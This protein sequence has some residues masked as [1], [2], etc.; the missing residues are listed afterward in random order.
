M[1]KLATA[2][3]I[4]NAVKTLTTMADTGA[5]LVEEYWHVVGEYGAF[6]DEELATIGM[7]A[8]RLASCITFCEQVGLL[9]SGGITTPAEYRV[10]LDIVRRIA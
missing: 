8:A 7:T 5:P 2:T 6:T 9:L 10:T 1:A 3:S 4:V